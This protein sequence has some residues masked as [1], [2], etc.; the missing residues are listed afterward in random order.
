M[1]APNPLLDPEAIENLRALGEPGDDSF[2]REIIGIYLA[3]TPQRLAELRAAHAAGDQAVFVRA[4]H[5]IKGSSANVGAAQV[6][7]LAEQLEH[8]AKAGPIAP[9]LPQVEELAGAFAETERALQGLL[10]G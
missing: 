10:G 5:T 7:A 2:L 3:D 6:R 8:A 9:L 1:S 4:A